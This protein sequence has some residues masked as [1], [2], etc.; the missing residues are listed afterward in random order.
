MGIKKILFNGAG[1]L[2]LLFIASLVYHCKNGKTESDYFNPEVLATHFNGEQFVGSE[3]CL[4]CHADIYKT[5]LETAHYNTSAIADSK[6]VKGSFKNGANIL[7]LKDVS[8]EMRQEGDSLF[9]YTTIKNRNVDV[10]PSTF[11]IVIGSGVKGQS[12]LTWEDDELFQLQTSYYTPSDNWVNSP[13]FPTYSYTRPIG[14]ACLK[15]HVTYATNRNPSKFGNQYDKKRMVYG[16]DCERCHRPSAKHVAYHKNNLEVSLP[17]FTMSWTGLSRQQR[18]D[19]C[20]QCHS[21]LRQ[22]LLKG[23]PFSFVV[24]ENLKEYSRNYNKAPVDNSKLDVHGNQ[25]GLL[26]SSECFKQTATM[27]CTTCHDPHKNQRGNAVYFNQKC[28]EC[29]TTDSVVCAAE[30]SQ[31]NEM[32]NNC[33][34]CHMPTMPSNSMTVELTQDSL[35][36]PFYVRT[37]LI[38][39]YPKKLWGNQ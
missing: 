15:C 8:F 20:A 30:N 11:D 25:Y 27:D 28:M 5:H 36:T 38:D 21:G 2:S 18:L 37:H 9:Q 29:H 23:T 24:G 31:I 33:I 14:D 10:V 19:A 7:D 12:Y 26:T 17:K 4:E 13:S 22:E 6:T 3:T 32:D 34:A 35:E 1:L 16:I 39:V